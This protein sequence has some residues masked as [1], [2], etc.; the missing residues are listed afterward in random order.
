MSFINNVM[1]NTG[2]LLS[3]VREGVFSGCQFLSYVSSTISVSQ[4]LSINMTNCTVAHSLL[5]SSF[6]GNL[7]LISFGEMTQ[8]ALQN[9]TLFNN[10]LS[11]ASLNGND[12]TFILI[13]NV[14]QLKVQGLS[15]LSSNIV[16]ADAIKVATLVLL[17]GCNSRM[18]LSNWSLMNATFNTYSATLSSAIHFD[19]QNTSV[20]IETMNLKGIITQSEGTQLSL[21]LASNCSIS[22]ESSV[23]DYSGVFISYEAKA[24]AIVTLRHNQLFAKRSARR[25]LL[26]STNP[27]SLVSLQTTNLTFMKEDSNVPA[28]RS[29]LFS[30]KERENLSFQ[31]VITPASLYQ[32]FNGTEPFT[33]PKLLDGREVV[34]RLMSGQSYNLTISA[35]LFNLNPVYHYF[36]LQ[37]MNPMSGIKLET[38]TYGM[39]QT[40]LISFPNV[41]LVG[42][43]GRHSLRLLQL[44]NDSMVFSG[45]LQVEI[46][47]CELPLLSHRTPFQNISRCVGE[48]H[49]NMIMC[50][51]AKLTLD[52]RTCM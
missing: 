35:S 27:T 8:L 46:V 12:V 2:L 32:L 25:L 34:P 13:T 42:N 28:M 45:I 23:I 40:G 49:N 16:A 36:S 39:Y 4:A 21:N 51:S 24:P 15:M 52:I 41:I 19:I 44:T 20:T 31:G 9:L 30:Q 50:Q 3:S 11:S 5:T 14:E 1:L 10:S 7:D 6:Q 37:V 26:L 43:E 29:V 17:R 22:V 38:Q 47:E 18:L 33:L 48:S